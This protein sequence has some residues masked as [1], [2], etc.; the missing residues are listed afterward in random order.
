MV[1]REEIDAFYEGLREGVY[2][3]AYMK[4]GT[5][6]VGTTGKTLKQAYNEIE[7][8]RQLALKN[9]GFADGNTDI[10]E[11]NSGVGQEYTC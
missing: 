2:M 1:T 4:D 6:Y 10:S 7:V 9:K 11:G 3:Y 5:Y 8:E